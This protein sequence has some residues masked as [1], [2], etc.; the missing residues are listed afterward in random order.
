MGHYTLGFVQAQTGD[1]QAA[2]DAT[3]VARRLSPF[4]PML[5]AMC[6]A[7]AFALFRLERCEEAAEWALKAAEKPNAH[8][9][10]HAIAALVLAAA[11]RLEESLREAGMVRY[12]RPSYSIENFLSS[13]RVLSDQERTYRIAANRIGIG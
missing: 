1:P 7:R 10:V 4:D 6:A 3:D 13:F 11:W 9:H 8:A 5:Y 2:V 12:L